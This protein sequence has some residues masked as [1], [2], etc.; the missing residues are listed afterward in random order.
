MTKEGRGVGKMET[1]TELT[2]VDFLS[3]FLSVFIILIGIRSI[4][5]LL[6]WLIHKLGLETKWMR[7]KRKEHELLVQTAQN[8]SELQAKHRED[9]AAAI[10]ARDAQINSLMLAQREV[11]ADKINQKYKYY[12]SLKGIPEDEI[13]EFAN[14]HFAYKQIGGNH[15]GDAK[16]EYCIN[17]LPII[18]VKTKLIF[19]SEEAK[20]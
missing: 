16:Y 10:S 17:H 7:A 14:L 15:M 4:T 18:P 12:I 19:E 1:I 5:S 6:E 13:D 8:L 20:T 9:F 11:L 2:K 3:L